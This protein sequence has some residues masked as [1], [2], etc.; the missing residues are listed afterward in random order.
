MCAIGAKPERK[1]HCPSRGGGP[2]VGLHSGK[3]LRRYKITVNGLAYEV[4]VEEIGA[5]HATE[6]HRDPQ[7]AAPAPLQ[8]QTPEVQAAPAA[9]PARTAEPA[10]KAA[11]ETGHGKGRTA[12]APAAAPAGGTVVS[13]PLPGAVLDVKVSA[14]DSVHEGQVVAVL[15]AMKMEN[16]IIAPCSGTVRAVYVHPGSAVSL[17]EPLIEIE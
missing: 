6:A 4:E 1:G 7:Q 16:E 5:A 9:A 14:G 2:H 17:G 11:I 13:A 15:E 8:T 3:P 12:K 10:A